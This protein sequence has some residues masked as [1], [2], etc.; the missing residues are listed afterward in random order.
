MPLGKGALVTPDKGHQAAR[1]MKC[2]TLRSLR[3]LHIR[4]AI[5]KDLR[6][7]GLCAIFPSLQQRVR[8]TRNQ[9]RQQFSFHEES[10]PT[11]AHGWVPHFASL[12]SLKTL[13]FL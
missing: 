9:P 1:G 10:D 6:P 7:S 3:V 11:G 13:I 12:R 8:R 5:L 2:Q 4:K